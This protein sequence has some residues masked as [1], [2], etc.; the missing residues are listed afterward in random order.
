MFQQVWLQVLTGLQD[1]L[2]TQILQWIT[3]LL[4]N[5]FPH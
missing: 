2:G 1:F 5:L 3:G 4:G